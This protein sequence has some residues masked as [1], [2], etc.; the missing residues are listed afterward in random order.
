MAAGSKAW[1]C[2]RWLAGIADSNPGEGI[3][4]AL[5]SVVYYKV[6]GSAS[7]RSLVQRSPTECGVSECYLKTVIVR[8]PKPTTASVITLIQVMHCFNISLSHTMAIETC[9]TKEL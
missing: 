1:V 2:D 8:R 7:G 4:V 3:N 5:V 6:A 9:R